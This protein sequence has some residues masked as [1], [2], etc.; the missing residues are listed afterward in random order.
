MTEL[1]QVGLITQIK[2]LWYRI[3]NWLSS[4]LG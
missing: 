1:T 3:S 4:P 2:Q